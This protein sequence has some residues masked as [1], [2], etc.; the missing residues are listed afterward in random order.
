[1]KTGIHPAIHQTKVTCVCGAS[2]TINGTLNELSTEI[3]MSCHPHYTG[4]K[5]LVDSEGRVDKFMSKFK[6]ANDN[7]TEA[8]AA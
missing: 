1:M 5:K 2:Y 3:C 4:K 7:T 6:T 8:K